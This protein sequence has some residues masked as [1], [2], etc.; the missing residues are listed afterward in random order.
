[1]S[2]YAR[3]RVVSTQDYI[4]PVRDGKTFNGWTVEELIEEWFKGQFDLNRYHV[5]RDG[6][7]LGGS[8]VLVEAKQV[9]LDG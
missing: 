2:E 6:S 3:I 5:T 7:I 9:P 4:V 1:M 8:K